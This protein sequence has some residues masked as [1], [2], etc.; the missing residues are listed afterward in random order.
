[1]IILSTEMAL[2]CTLPICLLRR[3]APLLNMH[4]ANK[5]VHY[6]VVLEKFCNTLIELCDGIQQ[7]FSRNKARKPLAREYKWN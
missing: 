4:R 2:F 1:M 5:V 6:S 7:L 3:F